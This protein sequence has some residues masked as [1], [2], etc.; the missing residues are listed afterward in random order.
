MNKISLKSVFCSYIRRRLKTL[1][2]LLLFSAVFVVIFLLAELE[3]EIILYAFLLCGFMGLVYAVFDFAAYYRKY[4]Q[5]K[6]IASRGF[7]SLD[8]LPESNDINEDM[9]LEIIRLLYAEKSRLEEEKN[10]ITT[11]MSDY[12]TMWAHQIK[13]PISAMRLLLSESENQRDKAVLL[14]LFKIEQYADMVLQYQ[15][16]ESM[17]TDLIFKPCDL[18]DLAKQAVRKY[19]QFFIRKKLKL[20]ME[21]FSCVVLTDEKWAVFVIGQVISNAV[22]YTRTGEISIYLHSE[23][24]K[25][26]VI[27]DTG[28]GIAKE[29]LPRIFERGYTGFNGRLDK[30]STGIGLYLCKKIMT[31][32]KQKIYALSEEGKGTKVILDFDSEEIE[33][34]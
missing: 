29:D 8:T 30:K 23:K 18:Y 2:M 28:I 9:Y 15:R 3:T 12:Y 27:E 33:I 32:M 16:L 21:E 4:V 14:E 31:N 10:A 1:A 20:N 5:L 19:A 22:K 26:L 25:A 11:D 17:T 7:V 24:P 6:D 13:I 34:E